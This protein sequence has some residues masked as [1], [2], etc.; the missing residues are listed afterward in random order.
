MRTTRLLTAVLAFCL[1]GLVPFAAAAPATAAEP[2]ARTVAAAPATASGA[3]DR[4][5]TTRKVVFKFRKTGNR[6]FRFVGD[7]Q[8]A[9][10]KK[11][12]LLR[13]NT[14]KGKYRTFR[15]TRTDGRGKYTFANLGKTGYYGVKV[16]SDKKYAKSYSNVIRVYYS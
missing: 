13:S 1:I 2:H 6:S 16:P 12:Y 15:T 10:K 11:I 7:V 5:R 14:K 3:A 8:G 4:A 9:N